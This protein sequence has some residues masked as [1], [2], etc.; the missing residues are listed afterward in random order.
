M[1]LPPTRRARSSTWSPQADTNTIE[2]HGLSGDDGSAVLSWG[3]S[4]AEAELF[5]L[6]VQAIDTPAAS[7]TPDQQNAVAWMQA[8]EEREAEQAAQDA[9]LEYVKWAGLDEATYSSLIAGDADESDLQSFLSAAPEPLGLGADGYCDYEAPSPYQSDYTAPSSCGGSGDIGGL[10]GGPPT[11][12]Y[13]QFTSWGEADAAYSLQ[14]SLGAV[15]E[16]AE[17][18][19]GLDFGAAVVGAGGGRRRP[20]FGLGLRLVDQHSAAIAARSCNVLR[21]MEK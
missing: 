13:D 14:S 1:P 2:D 15:Q 6:I 5:A 17:I 10:L 11:P 3:R 9:G 12:S 21:G 7:Q 4:D 19:A 8:V 18:A 20:Q 16:G